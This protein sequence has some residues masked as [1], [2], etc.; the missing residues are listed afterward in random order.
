MMVSKGNARPS[1]EAI[2]ALRHELGLDRPLP[3]RY[4]AWLLSAIQG[5]FSR[6]WMT[7]APVATLIGQR[8][9][10]TLF[11]GTAVLLSGAFGTIAFGGIAAA[12]PGGIVDH[13][14]RVIAVLGTAIP[15]FV[16][17]L[18]AIRFI[19]VGLGLGSVIGDGTARTIA[20]PA[21]VGALGLTAYWVRPFRAL[22]KDALSSDWALVLMARGMDWKA[23]LFFHAIPNALVNF[24]PFIGI[25]LAGTLAGSIFIENVF[26]WPG[27]GPF[28]IDAIKRRDLPIVQAFALMTVAFYIASTALTDALS[29][30]LAPSTSRRGAVR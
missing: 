1:P 13:I 19:A 29:S 20:M 23:L 11:L 12:V 9:G 15:S 14:M 25:G 6:S 18:L 28:V 8:L 4:G 24:L 22:V 2:T 26:S 3:A 10:A 16:L 5:D 30:L 17:G 7:G 27:I 21:A